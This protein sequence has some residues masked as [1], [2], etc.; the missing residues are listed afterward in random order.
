MLITRLLVFHRKF[1]LMAVSHDD[2]TDGWL[3][4]NMTSAYTKVFVYIH[5]RCRI[6]NTQT[7]LGKVQVSPQ[8]SGGSQ[9]HHHL[10]GRRRQCC[11]FWQVLEMIFWK[12]KKYYNSFWLTDCEIADVSINASLCFS[13]FFFSP[14]ILSR[15]TT[16]KVWHVPTA[17][18]QRNLGGHSGGVT[19]LSAPPP[20]YCRRLGTHKHTHRL[21]L[22][23]AR[24]S[25]E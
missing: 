6:Q 21:A 13:L 18:E 2:I 7:N 8:N 4:K 14:T 3:E 9:W 24:E 19:C 20:E 11:D 12:I 23:Q 5:C 16:V 1:C 25:K 15:D 10:C 17:T 22:S